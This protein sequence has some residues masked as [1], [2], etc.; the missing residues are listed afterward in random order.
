MGTSDLSMADTLCHFMVGGHKR[1]LV[2]LNPKAPSRI[3][4]NFVASKNNIKKT[5]RA[6]APSS[7]MF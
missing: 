1:P 5:Y 6:V 3:C 7:E 4:N 2:R